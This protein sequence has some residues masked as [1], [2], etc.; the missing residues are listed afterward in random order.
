MASIRP[1]TPAEIRSS[2][3]TPSGSRDQIRSPLYLTSGRYISTSR[4]RSSWLSGSCLE[5]DPELLD[6]FG[7]HVVIAM[8]SSVIALAARGLRSFW[9]SH[10]RLRRQM[11]RGQRYWMPLL[12]L[13]TC[14][15]AYLFPAQS[16][17]SGCA[18]SIGSQPALRAAI[19]RRPP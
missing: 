7:R 10:C 16:A 17:S 2:S 9:A 11:R 19:H 3:S 18:A 13:S 8:P 1:K 6:I 14:R 12:V 5:F 15:A 4:L